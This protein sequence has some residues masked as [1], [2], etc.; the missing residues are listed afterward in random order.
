MFSKVRANSEMKITFL[1]IPFN[2]IQ[3]SV[4]FC[5]LYPRG[6]T[7]EGSTTYNPWSCCQVLVRLKELMVSQENFWICSFCLFYL[8]MRRNFRK[9]GFFTFAPKQ[10]F[11]LNHSTR[12]YVE[13]LSFKQPKRAILNGCISKARTNSEIRLAFSES[14]FNFLESRLFY[15]RSTHLGTWQW[16]PPHINPGIPASGSPGSKS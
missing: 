15:A 16:A 4:V 5:M 14:S 13:K 2:F 3:N 11:Y 6:Y 8:E 12:E 10:C 9:N 1:K 7:A